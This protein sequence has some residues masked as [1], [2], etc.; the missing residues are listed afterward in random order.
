MLWLLLCLQD[1]LNTTLVVVVVAATQTWHTFPSY[2]INPRDGFSLL[3]FAKLY[4]FLRSLRHV[5]CTITT[6]GCFGQCSYMTAW[7]IWCNYALIGKRTLYA[8]I[9]RDH[10][11]RRLSIEDHSIV[12]V[13]EKDKNRLTTIIDTVKKNRGGRRRIIAKTMNWQLNNDLQLNNDSS[14]HGQPQATQGKSE[15]ERMSDKKRV[16][17]SI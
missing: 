7:A 2:I 15:I 1:T 4:S 10:W 11:H 6:F 5:W 8:V 3:Y 12:V 14:P 16:L 17:P 13:V 9:M